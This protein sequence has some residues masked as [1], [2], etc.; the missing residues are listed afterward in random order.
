MP[1][2]QYKATKVK[3]EYG[4]FDSKGEYNRFLE[5]QLLE[6][7]GEISGLYV[8]PRLDLV[9]NGVKIGRYTGDFLYLENGKQVI[10]DFKGYQTATFK[11]RWKIAKALYGDKY[12]FRITKA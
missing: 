6:K 3:T 11:L 1:Q 2:F 10:E 5:L 8:H 4:T 9:I 12:I 7:A